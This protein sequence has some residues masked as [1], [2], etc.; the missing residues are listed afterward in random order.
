VYGGTTGFGAS[1][2]NTIF[3]VVNHT[4]TTSSIT[5]TSGTYC[6]TGGI[7]VPGANATNSATGNPASPYSSQIFV[8]V[9]G[10]AALSGTINTVTV[11]LNN[12]STN[13]MQNQD[14][15]LVGPTGQTLDFFSQSGTGA[16][17]ASFATVT[18]SD[19]GSSGHL[20]QGSPVVSGSIYQPTSNIS[21]NPTVYCRVADMVGQTCGGV[22]VTEGAPNSFTFSSPKGLGTLGG[23]FGGTSPN[24]TWK[25]FVIA[26]GSSNGTLGSWC[27][28]F[29]DS[30]GDPTQTTLVSSQNPSFTT[31]PLNSVTFTA[32][33]T[34]TNIPGTLINTGTVAFT[35]DGATI[36]GCG[37]VPVNT[38]AG[39]GGTSVCTTT[40]LP[41]GAHTIVATY[42]GTATLGTSHNTTTLIQRV[43]NHT[44]LSINGATYTY[45]N[46][47]QVQAPAGEPTNAVRGIAA[48]WGS[49]IFATNLPGTLNTATVSVTNFLWTRPDWLQ[50]LLVGPTGTSIDFLSQ[51]GT[52]NPVGNAGAG[53]GGIAFTVADGGATLVNAAPSNGSTVKPYSGV[54]NNV[55]DSAPIGPGQTGPAAGFVYAAPASNR[56]FTGANSVF[57]GGAGSVFNG[58]GTWSLFMESLFNGG[59]GGVGSWCVNLTENL[60]DISLTT[61]PMSHSPASFT[62]GQT[63]S[64]TVTATNAG[65]GP[66][67][68]P[69][70][71]IT[72]TLPAGLTFTSGTGTGWTCS[73]VAQLVTCTNPTPIAAGSNSAVTINFTVGNT[74]ADTISTSATI[75]PG[76]GGDNTPANNTT[77]SGNITVIGTVLTINKTHTDPFTQGQVGAQYQITV[78]NTGASG[79]S[80]GP[81]LAAGTIV[82][83]DAMPSA[84]TLT[85][86]SGG[87]TWNCLPPASGVNCTL[88]GSLAVG[89]TT[90]AI[91][92]TVTVSNTLLGPVTN[93]AILTATTDQIGPAG[94]NNHDDVT[95]I[96]QVPTQ[97]AVNAG[98]T[99]QSATV[100][101]AFANPLA[102]TV[103]DAGNNGVAGVNVTFTAPGSGASG[104]FSNSTATITVATNASGVAAAPFTANATAGGPYTVTA[105]ATGLTTV[106]FSLTNT[107]GAA[108][109]MTA[110]AGT[111]PQSATVSTAFANALAVTVRDTGNNAVAGVNVTFTA[112][113]SCASG[114]FSNSTT[115][116]TVATNAS[117]V[118]SAPFTANATTGG[119][120]TVTAAATGLT[121]V[122]FSLTNTAGAA[123]SMTANAGTTPQSATV[124]TAFANALAVTV[125]DAGNNAVAGVNV[126]FTAP[127]S[128]A[129]GV[130]SNSTATITVATNA[131]G[132]ASAPFTANATAG[133]PYTVTAAATG[134]TTVNFSLTN[135]TAP[136]VVSYSVLFGTQSYN[137][138]GSARVR[139]PWQITGIRVTFSTII[140]S[141]NIN[142][143]TGVT[144]TGFSG[145][146]T[147]TLTWTIS[148]VALGNLA[149]VLAGSGA[150]ALQDAGGNGLTGGA[151]FAQ[152]LK[153][154]WG[155]FNDDGV[156][157]STDFALVN[158]A[159]S[160]PYNIFADA[161]GDGVVDITDVNIVRGRN[162][163]S[164]P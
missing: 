141:G 127:G 82:V 123:A 41:E 116:I 21:G 160:L 45:C 67:G 87:A 42:S 48:P 75:T 56:T 163:T 53:T 103:R 65:P 52:I 14:L 144:T 102:V 111:T 94:N 64:V 26:D 155:D 54:A 72:D 90:N 162:G 47:G 138:I 161:N 121:T 132:V 109:S 113:G 149:T 146:G 18:I 153:V 137:V 44:T 5:A 96:T 145:L 39:G 119:P 80:S 157:T 4:T 139:L 114:V 63:G 69:T 16:V 108:A 1:T 28:N 73:A 142:S 129:S 99:P 125:K 110:N 30:T 2:S 20:P 98:T 23:Q 27:L 74:T 57:G 40:T 151:G 33:V 77:T 31:A 93:T 131:S 88:V 25:L 159:R 17:A 133:G 89:A 112:P 124:G 78:K 143:L 81:G 106:N 71:T 11:T 24:G 22:L 36:S 8:G 83:T 105:A 158:N 154:L 79:T 49:N 38:Q 12:V 51:L 29:S 66:T 85:A 95:N 117:G 134:L 34:D 126:T 19:T 50:S 122:N 62:R 120:Y 32:T 91:T 115:T 60:P 58:N 55:Y 61:T 101:T 35:S 118:A 13:E 164:L 104:R 70:L 148:P 3:Q 59:F 100:N 135:T 107:A 136:T 130:F 97:M 128:G 46:P 10:T 84:F 147:N 152:A 6:N 37:A 15:M 150:D 43:D 9:N 140:A 7:T 76:T 92:A 156:V 86:V 68:N